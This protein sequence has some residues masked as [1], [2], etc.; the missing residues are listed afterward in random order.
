L[1]QQRQALLIIVLMCPLKWRGDFD[2]GIREM[3]A[4]HRELIGHIVQL[5]KELGSGAAAGN[6]LRVLE[7]IYALI[8]E[9]FAVEERV[10]QKIHYAAYAD[11]KEDHETLLDELREIM[12]EVEQD[13]VFDDVQW[14]A[15]LDRWFGDHFR[16]HD[17]RFYSS[18]LD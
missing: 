9:H 5:Q 10:M 13:G 2:T 15:D 12:D 14:I 4:E 17:A 16:T 7:R 18:S 11:H 1:I 6:V 8:A 3:D